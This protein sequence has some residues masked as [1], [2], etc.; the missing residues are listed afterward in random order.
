MS[1][2]LE[3]GSVEANNAISALFSDSPPILIEVRFP[4]MG[5]S[6]D[7]YLCD[8]P[9][10]LVEIVDKLGASEELHL[11]SVWDLQNPKGELRLKK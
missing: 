10:E 3:L 2:C 4:R 7:W 8:D 6:P 9:Q 11:S 1:Q 5:T